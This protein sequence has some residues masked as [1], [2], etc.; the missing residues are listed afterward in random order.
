MVSLKPNFDLTGY[1]YTMLIVHAVVRVT[2]YLLNSRV[3]DY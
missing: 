3:V 1:G 2:T